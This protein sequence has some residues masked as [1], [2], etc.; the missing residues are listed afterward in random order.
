MQIDFG[1][2]VAFSGIQAVTLK[3]GV[4]KREPPKGSHR[5]G[6]TERELPIIAVNQ[7][8]PAASV[9][10]L[11]QLRPGAKFPFR[12]FFYRSPEFCPGGLFSGLLGVPASLLSCSRSLNVSPN[13]SRST[14]AD[15]ILGG[16]GF[17]RAIFGGH[18]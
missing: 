8:F 15:P 14:P 13:S 18:L 2:A 12:L 7:G 5:K 1:A 16:L 4:A 3:K 9:S 11:A 10:G 17:Y 6:A